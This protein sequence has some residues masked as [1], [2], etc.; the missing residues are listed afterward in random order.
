MGCWGRGL[1]WRGSGLGFGEVWG[2]GLRASVFEEKRRL[3]M[4]KQTDSPETE[5]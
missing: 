3:E 4:R 2:P 1:E 5:L